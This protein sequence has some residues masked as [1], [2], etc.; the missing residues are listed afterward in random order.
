MKIGAN[1]L[2]WGNRVQDLRRMLDLL[3]VH[4]CEG[5]E[6][7]QRPE[8]LGDPFELHQ[9]L[10]NRGLT[11]LGLSGGTV[12]ERIKFCAGVLKPQYLYVDG[13]DEAE[14][15]DARF[16]G[17]PLAIHPHIFKPKHRLA[18]IEVELRDHPELRFLP[19]VAHLTIAGDSPSNAV[20]QW[21]D[22]LAAVH[23][24]DW[25]PAY[26]RSSHRYGRGFVELG[27]GIVNFD[28]L[29][30]KLRSIRYNGWLVFEQ[31]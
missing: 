14:A 25:T 6:F 7:S 31:G 24:K 13:W 22:R 1:T 26:G 5:V 15:R 9:L 12:E 23:V 16:A 20:G 11:L 8:Q 30:E 10:G 3:A 27:K 29:F 18:D 17:L 21:R 28:Q 4:G 2:L 19:D